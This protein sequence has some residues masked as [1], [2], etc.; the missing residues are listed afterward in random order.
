MG[1]LKQICVT[2]PVERDHKC[3]NQSKYLNLYVMSHWNVIEM[4]QV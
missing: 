2:H 1:V 3:L 4:L